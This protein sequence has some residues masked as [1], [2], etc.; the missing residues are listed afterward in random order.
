MVA[1]MRV[2]VLTA[3]SLIPP[4]WLSRLQPQW[5]SLKVAL[6]PR[7]ISQF[8]NRSKAV[9]RLKVSNHNSV[10]YSSLSKVVIHNLKANLRRDLHSSRR[11][12]DL[13]LNKPR[14]SK[15]VMLNLKVI[16]LRSLKPRL[17]LLI[18]LTALMTIYRSRV[19]YFKKYTCELLT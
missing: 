1:K 7:A 11:K 16:Q 4:R 18:T 5:A 6:L 17:S 9:S 15:E 10:L 12:V 8:N 19:L 13:L 14:L 2:W 3:V